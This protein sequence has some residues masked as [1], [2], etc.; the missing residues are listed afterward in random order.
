MNKQ[1]N[2]FL[3]QYEKK[4]SELESILSKDNELSTE[5][6]RKAEEIN[7]E[8]KNLKDKIE[9]FHHSE[10]NLEVHKKYLYEPNDT[11]PIAAIAQKTGETILN[12]NGS[13]NEEGEGVL[14]WKT[15]S[16]ISS[17]EYKSAFRNYIRKGEWGLSKTEYKSL[18]VGQDAEGGYLVPADMLGK[19]VEKDPSDAG[20]MNLVTNIQTSRDNLLI[21]RVDYYADDTYTNGMRAT[22]TGENIENDLSHEVK[23][24]KF[25]Q[26]NIPVHT[27]MLSLR[28]T[29]DMVEDASFPIQKWC[30]DKFRE[31]IHMLYESS[32]LAGTGSGQPEGILTAAGKTGGPSI[33]NLNEQNKISAEKLSQLAFSIPEQ[34]LHK[35]K[36]IMNYNLTGYQLSLL[37]DGIGRSLWGEGFGDSGLEK[38]YYQRK[39]FGHP[40]HFSNHMPAHDK[41]K[42]S[43]IFGDLSGYYLVQRS[44]ISIQVLREVEALKNRLVVVGRVRFGGKVVEPWKIKVGRANIENKEVD[45]SKN[46]SK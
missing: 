3:E 45:A 24:S 17:N 2:H 34:Y 13:Y 27:A 36:W 20:L 14:R 8:L 33:M 25:Q 43:M 1:K 16:E 30:V 28:I 31:S 21:P 22:W 12:G 32:I 9:F 44:G 4:T 39:L 5:D 29:N 23:H 6:M 41:N 40:V 10:K 19:I 42:M 26:V 7:V 11:M 37:K 46:V 15:Y 38:S 18:Q 35:S